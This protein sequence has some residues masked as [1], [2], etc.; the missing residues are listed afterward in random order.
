MNR[1]YEQICANDS[2]VPSVSVQQ[3]TVLYM[4]VCFFSVLRRCARSVHK[5]HADLSRA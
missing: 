5:N 2:D 1:S 3:T 4:F